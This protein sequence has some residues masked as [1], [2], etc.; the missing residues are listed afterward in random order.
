M[1]AH[2]QE[3]FTLRHRP[4][5]EINRQVGD[6]LGN[7]TSDLLVA[8]LR[9]EVGVVIAALSRLYHPLVKSGRFTLKM[10]LAENAGLVACGL[11]DFRE[12]HL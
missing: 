11:Q 3:W 2:E 5:H 12:C 8:L 4:F 9:D 6:D 1:L 10:P 7:I